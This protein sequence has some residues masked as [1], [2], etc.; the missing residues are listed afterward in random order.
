MYSE[1]YFLCNKEL[2]KNQENWASNNFQIVGNIF[3]E[4]VAL[5][6]LIKFK[7]L[8]QLTN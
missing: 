5:Q 2:Q 8:G 1:N 6:N 3:Q 7:L 4:N